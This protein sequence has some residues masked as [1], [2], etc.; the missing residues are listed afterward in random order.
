MNI[1]Q[2]GIKSSEEVYSFCFGII[3]KKYTTEYATEFYLNKF[4]LDAV[5]IGDEIGFRYNSEDL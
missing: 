1:Y 4:I 2:Y 3:C 5:T